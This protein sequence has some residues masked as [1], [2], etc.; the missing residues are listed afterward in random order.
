MFAMAFVTYALAAL[1][2]SRLIPLTIVLVSIGGFPLG[3][4]SIPKDGLT[5]RAVT[6]SGSIVGANLGSVLLRE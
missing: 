6:M 1:V 2:S 4:V 3:I 5:Y